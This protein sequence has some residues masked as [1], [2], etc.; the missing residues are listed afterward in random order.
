MMIMC[1]QQDTIVPR[2]LPQLG[3]SNMHTRLPPSFSRS[4]GNPP[5]RG[6]IWPRLPFK[7][8]GGRFR[9]PMRDRDN[10]VLAIRIETLWF[11]DDVSDTDRGAILQ[12]GYNLSD[13]S[14][15]YSVLG[16]PQSVTQV[17]DRMEVKYRG[18]AH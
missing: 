7:G 11:R 14:N 13:L 1:E 15:G 6:P 16:G 18:R 5:R 10:E 12:A 4:G 9:F 17:V 3:A 8:N 2:S